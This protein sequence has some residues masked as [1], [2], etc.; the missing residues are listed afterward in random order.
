MRSRSRRRKL[1]LSRRLLLA[2]TAGVALL[3]LA[4]PAFAVTVINGGFETGTLSGWTVADQAG[5]SGTWVAYS[6]AMPPSGGCPPA[7]FAASGDVR[8]HD[9]SE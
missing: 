8:R 5:G 2:L 9:R 6:N 4:S 7:P 3:A 1:E